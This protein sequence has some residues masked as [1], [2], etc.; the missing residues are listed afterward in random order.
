MPLCLGTSRFVRAMRIPQSLCWAPDV[1]TFCPF[2]TKA[3][4][5]RTAR[6]LSAAR[7]DPASGSENSWH[8][9]SSPRSMAGR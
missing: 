9:T 4:P 5:S 2:T 8:H 7:S 6:L 1:H 3:S